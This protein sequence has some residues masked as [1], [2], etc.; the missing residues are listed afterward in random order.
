MIST[1]PHPPDVP[2][3][4]PHLRRWSEMAFAALLISS[5]ASHSIHRSVGLVAVFVLTLIISS[6]VLLHPCKPLVLR[7]ARAFEAH[8][9]K[10]LTVLVI[11]F[12]AS[13]LVLFGYMI[14][15]IN[16]PGMHLD[17]LTL[18]ACIPAWIAIAVCAFSGVEL[19][20]CEHMH[21]KRTGSKS[22]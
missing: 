15:F 4:T 17:N 10:L 20:Y 3:V 8:S 6:W 11:M 18:R 21:V 12:V 7:Y 2:D 5:V 14:F 22:N 9:P 19:A 13:G 16:H 1:A